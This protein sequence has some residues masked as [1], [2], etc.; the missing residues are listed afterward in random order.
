MIR[1]AC[2]ILAPALLLA[3]CGQRE[4]LRPAPGGALPIKP[5]MARE[6]PTANELLTP[7][8]EARPERETEPMRRSR[9]RTEDPFDLPPAS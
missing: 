9:E 1:A 5:A 7:G 3:G 4:E 8:P 6:L 2:A